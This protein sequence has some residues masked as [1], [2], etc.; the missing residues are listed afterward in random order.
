MIYPPKEHVMAALLEIVAAIGVPER[1]KTL[2]SVVIVVASL[3]I[4]SWLFKRLSSKRI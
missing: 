4:V 3:M 2:H 1:A